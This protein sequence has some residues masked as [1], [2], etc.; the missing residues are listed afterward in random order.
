MGLSKSLN[1]YIDLYNFVKIIHYPRLDTVLMVE[2]FIRKH[3]G[4]YRKK[5][6]W[7]NLPRKMMYQTFCIIYDYL[8]E[9]GKIL[10]DKDRTVVWIWDPEG[11]KR[12]ISEGVRLR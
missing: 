2:K 10:L 3:S 4:D 7:Q 9:S 11:V 5:A 1:S 12:V 6:L 8:L